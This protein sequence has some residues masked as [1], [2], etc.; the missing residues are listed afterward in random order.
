MALLFLNKR[1]FPLGDY[2]IESHIMDMNIE[3]IFSINDTFVLQTTDCIYIIS[4]KS[5]ID[6]QVNSVIS[7]KPSK[8]YFILVY[9][10]SSVIYDLNGKSVIDTEFINSYNYDNIKN[11]YYCDDLC[12]YNND[13]L[14]M[15][16]NKFNKVSFKTK[17]FNK[18]IN[19]SSSLNNNILFVETLG[20]MMKHL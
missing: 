20:K 17:N 16:I 2:S 18:N 19:V 14:Y 1:I 12:I 4:N 10:N 7:L 9:E 15:Y 11:T 3:N 6:I 13:I 5:L 8:N